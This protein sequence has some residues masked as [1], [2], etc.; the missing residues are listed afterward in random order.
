MDF[1][2]DWTL[3]DARYVTKEAWESVVKDPDNKKLKNELAE[4]GTMY[5]NSLYVLNQFCK[6]ELARYR[7]ALVRHEPQA[8]QSRLLD[9]LYTSYAVNMEK[10]PFR[11][12][13]RFF[14]IE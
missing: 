13:F 9:E 2:L 4:A 5:T 10:D 12:F 6:P 7:Q 1:D 3:D 14:G 8:E 11:R